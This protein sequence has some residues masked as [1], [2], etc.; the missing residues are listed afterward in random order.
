M[1]QWAR[2]EDGAEARLVAAAIDDTVFAAAV[3][4]P[5]IHRSVQGQ[6]Q[7]EPW[8]EVRTPIAAMAAAGGMV[9]V[10]SEDGY[11]S[12]LEPSDA[13]EVLGATVAADA[14]EAVADRRGVWALSA[15]RQSL[16]HVNLDGHVDKRLT[17][18]EVDRLAAADHGV[19]YTTRNDSYL[20]FVGMDSDAVEPTDLGVPAERRGGL[21]P[22][23]PGVWVSVENGLLLAL[24]RGRHDVRQ[25]ADPPGAPVRNL[26]CVRTGLI[27]GDQLDGLF[28]LNFGLDDSVRCLP[29]GRSG[30][31]DTLVTDGQAA[32]AVSRPQGIP[33]GIRLGQ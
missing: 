14:A 26:L 4:S 13:A 1:A 9:I 5:A 19:W 28:M 18:D 33:I 24:E 27:G 10:V 25:M 30:Q 3:A 17:V 2:H 20:R 21:A 12:G 16:V 31:V 7:L 8:V 11:V 15:N 23:R 29:T 32:W 6:D 22:C